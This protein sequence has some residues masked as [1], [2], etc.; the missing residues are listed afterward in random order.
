MI[1]IYS[2][3]VKSRA[4]RI[5]LAVAALAV[6]AVFVAFGIFLLLGLAAVGTLV[7]AAVL[8]FR[9]LTGRRPSVIEMG[10]LNAELDPSLEVFPERSA[11]QPAPPSSQAH[12]LTS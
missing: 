11:A 3:D 6:G 1:R 9:R 12:K 7:G 10:R 5:A 4:A 8:V 2:L